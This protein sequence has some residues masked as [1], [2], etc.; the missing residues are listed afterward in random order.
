MQ[1]KHSTLNVQD[2]NLVT[3]K[4]KAQQKYVY[5]NTWPKTIL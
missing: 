5:E 4:L 3:D 1:E 2:W